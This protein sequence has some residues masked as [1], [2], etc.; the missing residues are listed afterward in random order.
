MQTAHG[1]HQA[2][3]QKVIDPVCGMP[4]DPARAG[5]LHVQRHGVLLL[6]SRMQTGIR[7]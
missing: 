7:R 3:A 2:S 4:I 1:D 6:L 5:K